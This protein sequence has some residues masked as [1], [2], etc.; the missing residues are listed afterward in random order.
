[1]PVEGGFEDGAEFIV[2]GP[3]SPGTVSSDETEDSGEDSGD[4]LTEESES[5]TDESDHFKN[6]KGS[7]DDGELQT[8]LTSQR[9]SHPGD[10]SMDTDAADEDEVLDVIF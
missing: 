10:I 9:H 3:G 2:L 7:S 5:E 4:E 6:S 8:S 1:M